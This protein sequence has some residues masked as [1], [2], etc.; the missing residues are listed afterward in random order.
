MPEQKP[1]E[2]LA[3][4]PV[5]QWDQLAATLY[6]RELAPRGYS[7]IKRGPFR[8]RVQSNIDFLSKDTVIRCQNIG[9]QLVRSFRDKVR[10]ELQG[11]MKDAEV[12]Q[13]TAIKERDSLPFYKFKA[14]RRQQE[15][16]EHYRTQIGLLHILIN[17]LDTIGIK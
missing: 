10:T 15:V 13:N 3:E 14:R 1:K 16:Y 7:E 11:R 17:E 2:N 4:L 8:G 6:K 12:K 9:A 5:K